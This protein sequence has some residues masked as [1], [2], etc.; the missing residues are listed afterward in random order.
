MCT[1]DMLLFC[2]LAS[3]ACPARGSG[4]IS[5]YDRR[6]DREL[7]AADPFTAPLF[8][9]CSSVVQRANDKTA[10]SIGGCP[11]MIGLLAHAVSIIAWKFCKGTGL[12]SSVVEP[13]R[14]PEPRASISI[15]FSHSSLT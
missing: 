13:S 4:V 7:L 8:G 3:I 10:F 12:F 2:M 14:Y 5:I 15:I 6:R 11:H 1:L 9:R